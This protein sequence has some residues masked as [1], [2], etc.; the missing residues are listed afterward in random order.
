MTKSKKSSNPLFTLDNGDEIGFEDLL[1]KIYTNSEEKNQNITATAQ[2]IMGLT[3]TL[4]D[5]VVMMPIL[6]DMQKASIAND[7]MLVKMAAIVQR[8]QNAK[9]KDAGLDNSL[10]SEEERKMLMDAVREAKSIPGSSSE[11]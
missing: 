4:S 7:D 1:K 2:R 10:I 3:K 6:V 9:A 11:G 8:S 5:M